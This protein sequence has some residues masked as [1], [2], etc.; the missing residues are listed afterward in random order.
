MRKSSGGPAGSSRIVKL[1]HLIG[2]RG[3]LPLADA[4]KFLGVS[5]MTVRRDLA[6]PGA[7]LACFG[8]HVV[9]LGA[10]AGAKYTLEAERDQH[11]SN[12]LLACRRA[13]E[14]VKAGDSLF[15]D[16]GTT[17]PHFAASLPVGVPLDVVCYS[18][19]VALILSRRPNTQ[20]MLLGGLYHASSATFFSDEALL[21]LKRLGLSKAFISAGGVHGRRGASC[22]NFS[23]VPIKQAAMANAAESILVVD[24]SKLGGVKPAFF[25]PLGQFSR[26]IVGGA[27]ARQ[28]LARFKGKK[29]QVVH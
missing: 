23:E 28:Q 3:A 22:S 19:N 21:F 14:L 10:G 1:Q 6:V 4:A 7:P 27:P 15:I 20:L 12:K 9:R 16:C 13:A 26:I 5:A 25:S 11:A 24:E 17:M 18:M 2:G 29:L 8:A